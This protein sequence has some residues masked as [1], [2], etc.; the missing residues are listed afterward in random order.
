MPF[1][2]SVAPFD[3]GMDNVFGVPEDYKPPFP[4]EGRIEQVTIELR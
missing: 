1:R 2:Y 3:V 4:L